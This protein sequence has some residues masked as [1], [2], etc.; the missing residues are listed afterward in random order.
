MPVRVRELVLFLEPGDM[1]SEVPQTAD[2]SLGVGWMK[3]HHTGLTSGES[4]S[5]TPCDI[6]ITPS[7]T[8]LFVF[9]YSYYFLIPEGVGL[10]FTVSMHVVC[11]IC[12]P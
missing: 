11:S 10:E 3:T 5:L 7:P 9:R 8:S 12:Q 4:C 6:N 1:V 2:S